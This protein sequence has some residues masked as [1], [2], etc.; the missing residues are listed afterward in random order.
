MAEI[1]RMGKCEANENI[2]RIITV[3]IFEKQ[4]LEKT[5]QNLFARSPKKV[6]IYFF[7]KKRPGTSCGH[8]IVFLEKNCPKWSSVGIKI[9]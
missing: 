7:L 1:T 9:I 4:R 6:S 8:V 3:G 2:I 5:S